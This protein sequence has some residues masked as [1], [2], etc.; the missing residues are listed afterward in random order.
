MHMYT[1]ELEESFHPII[2]V[3]PIEKMIFL[4]HCP[5]PRRVPCV[6][7][8]EELLVDEVVVDVWVVVVAFVSP[9][10]PTL[11]SKLRA[12]SEQKLGKV[13]FHCVLS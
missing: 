5:R 4:R 8:C 9:S 13:G 7:R 10:D 11:V 12:L 2:S 1:P 6:A 3:Y